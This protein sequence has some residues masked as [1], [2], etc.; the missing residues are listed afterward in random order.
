MRALANPTRLLIVEALANG[1]A[2]VSELTGLT[3][4]DVSTVSKHLAVLKGVGLVVAQK[5]GLNVFYSLACPCLSD[6][7]SCVDQINRNQARAL[8]RAAG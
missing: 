7:F 4:F 6:F 8:Q 3:D 1:E 5:R 2:P